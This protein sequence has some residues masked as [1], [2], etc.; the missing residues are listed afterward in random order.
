MGYTGQLEVNSN[1]EVVALQQAIHDMD[2]QIEEQKIKIDNTPN[3]ILRVSI[4]I[5]YYGLV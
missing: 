2:M 5:N 1:P 4:T 3:P